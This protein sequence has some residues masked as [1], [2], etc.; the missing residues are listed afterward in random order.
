MLKDYGMK[1]AVLGADTQIG[2]R[3]V[4]AAEDAGINVTSI[5]EN[6]S[7]STGNGPLIIKNVKDLT[8]ADL[9]KCHAVIDTLSFP[10]IESYSLD[11]LPFWHLHKLLANSL[12]KVIGV[13]SSACLYTDKKR[14]TFVKD[15]DGI[16][17]DDCEHKHNLAVEA[18][19]RIKEVKDLS[20][21][22]LCPPLV[23]DVKAYGSG[24]FVL[25]NDILPM[26]ISGS[27]FISLSDFCKS[28]VELLKVGGHNHCCVGVRSL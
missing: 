10:C 3:I 17:F 12:I 26:D 13:G 21:T 16:H 22:L 27:S 6:F 19:L 18:F 8:A 23:M 9:S 7:E 25:S 15:M 24:R 1:I 4:L 28:L 14:N 20:W 11:N 5:V 2:K